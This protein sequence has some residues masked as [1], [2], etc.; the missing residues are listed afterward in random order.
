MG[1]TGREGSGWEREE[2]GERGNRIRC[3]RGTGEK[4]RGPT[5]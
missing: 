4:T 3:G 2:G 5:E 1:D